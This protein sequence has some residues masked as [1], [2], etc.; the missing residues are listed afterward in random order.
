MVVDTSGA[1]ESEDVVILGDRAVERW[2]YRH[3]GGNSARG[4]TL[5][6]VEDG[7]IIE[8]L[9]YAKTSPPDSE[10]SYVNGPLS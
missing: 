6:R 4:V 10:N 1:F 8:A 5:F 2:R 9:A 7:K 3:A